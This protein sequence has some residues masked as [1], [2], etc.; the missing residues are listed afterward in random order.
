[1]KLDEVGDPG[2]QLFS[3]ARIKSTKGPHLSFW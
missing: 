3:T 1:M 2:P